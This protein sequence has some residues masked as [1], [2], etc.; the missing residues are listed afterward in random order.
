M[1]GKVPTIESGQA[2]TDRGKLA[3]VK[4]NRRISAERFVKQK[5]SN[6]MKSESHGRGAG[7]RVEMGWWSR[8]SLRP[9]I[10]SDARSIRVIHDD[11]MLRNIWKMAIPDAPQRN[12]TSAKEIISALSR[13]PSPIWGRLG[14]LAAGSHPHTMHPR[15]KF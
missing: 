9:G 14:G 6:A 12:G 7:A 3:I 4:G 11:V 10:S 1:G 5:A 2:V 8:I 13:S 15:I